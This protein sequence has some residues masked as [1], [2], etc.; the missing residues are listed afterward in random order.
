[1]CARD[2]GLGP[3]SNVQGP[4]EIVAEDLGVRSWT[5]PMQ[6]FSRVGKPGDLYEIRVIAWGYKVWGSRRG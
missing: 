1:M 4:E 5:G 3:V 6:M 2:W